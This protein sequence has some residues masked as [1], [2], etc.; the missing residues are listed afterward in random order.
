MATSQITNTVLD[1]SGAP[2]SGARVVARLLPFPG[3]RI[4]DSSEVS[5]TVETTTNGSGVWTIDLERQSNITPANTFYEVTELVRDGGR[6]SRRVW[7]I[8][9]PNANAALLACLII[10]PTANPSYETANSAGAARL[11]LDLV[12]EFGAAFDNATDDTA[13]WTSALAVAKAATA[14]GRPATVRM[15]AGTSKVTGLTVPSNITIEGH[16]EQSILLLT[17]GSNKNLLQSENYGSTSTIDTGI[18]LRNFMLLGNNTNQSATLHPQTYLTADTA[19]STSP[20]T[21]PVVDTTGFDSSGYLWLGS[22]R[23]AYTGKTSTTFTG[24]TALTSAT[25][26]KGCWITPFASKGHLVAFQA[27]RCRIENVFARSAAGS[28]LYFQGPGDGV[29]YGY[30]NVVEAVRIDRCYRFGIEVGE[31]NSDGQCGKVVVGDDNLMGGVLVRA[32][33]WSFETLHVTGTHDTMPLVPQ[34]ILVAANDFR[35]TNVFFDTLPGTGI[36]IDSGVRGT[37]ISDVDLSQVRYFHVSHGS[38]GGHGVLFRGPAANGAISRVRFSGFNLYAPV[39]YGFRNGPWTRTV[40]AQDLAALT[41]NKLQVTS[42]LDFAPSS[43]V[44]GSIKI[45]TDTM[46]Y[47]GRQMSQALSTADAGVGDTTLTVDSTDGFDSSGKFTLLALSTSGTYTAMTITYTG[48]T[49]TTFTGIP[50]SSTG[51]ITTAAPAGAGVAQHFFTGVTGG[52]LSVG[53]AASCFSSDLTPT[54]VAEMI[55]SDPIFRSFQVS[56]FGMQTADDWHLIGGVSGGKKMVSSGTVS[57]AAG[58][59]TASV[60]HGLAE[61]PT[62]KSLTPTADTQGRRWWATVDGTN[63]TVTLDSTATTNPITFDW[64]VE[65]V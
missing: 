26:R 8:S 48:K 43:D 9:V 54:P 14:Q 5:G 57:V 10:P 12:G 13:A 16:G 44:G 55:V 63:L 25:M 60:A 61:A 42:A 20:T 53:D 32:A 31:G 38:P 59:S 52:S 50:S 58:Q 29:T 18:Y 3:F 24:A 56:R 21:L 45:S 15:G 4:S 51:S 37:R 40:G 41:G 34:A 49:A 22:L 64:R 33:D 39:A 47:T 46:S 28:G 1:P 6:T 17:G 2:V 30:E 35:A 62:R 11:V 36:V 19:V 27:A 23:V 7:N 65:L